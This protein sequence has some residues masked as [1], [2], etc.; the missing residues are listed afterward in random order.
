MRL[1]SKRDCNNPHYKSSTT[2]SGSHMLC[3][4]LGSLENSLLEL[5][6]LEA[7]SW[8]FISHIMSHCLQAFL[9]HNLRQY[10]SL[11]E[12]NSWRGNRRSCWSPKL[13]VAG[14]ILQS[15]RESDPIL[16]VKKCISL[17]F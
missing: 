2:P 11:T 13:T 6:S 7:R 12:K 17:L 15:K 16:W 9:R 5:C 14:R 3:C 10:S 1:F 4:G 8:I